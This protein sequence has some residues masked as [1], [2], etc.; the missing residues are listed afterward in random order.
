VGVE[1]AKLDDKLVGGDR[2]WSKETWIA[3]NVP[4]WTPGRGEALYQSRYLSDEGRLFFNSRDALVPQDIN[5]DQDVYQYE[6]AGVGDCTGSSAIF[7]QASGGCVS[8]IS[9]GRAAGES[10]FLDASESGGDVF[11]LSGERLVAKDVDTALDVYD[12]HVCTSGAPCFSETTAPPP[13][14]T[15]EACRSAPAPQPGIFGSPSSA[16]FS[17]QG[18]LS[19][20]P[21]KRELT[22]KQKLAKALSACRKRYKHSKKRR[23]TCEKQ[24]RKRYGAKKARKTNFDKTAKR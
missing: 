6:P 13:C 8:L 9:S 12:A 20:A 22:P 19:P 23:S 11:F 21:P 14:E 17:G 4:G 2:V 1:Y 7:N 3:A 10:A 15:A 24:A 16:T 18:N 5:N